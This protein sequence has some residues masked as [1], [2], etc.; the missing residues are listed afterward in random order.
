[1]QHVENL[2]SFR[3][4]IFSESENRWKVGAQNEIFCVK[5]KKMSFGEKI[6][7]LFIGGHRQLE[8]ILCLMNTKIKQEQIKPGDRET[9]I[10]LRALVIKKVE[11]YNSKTCWIFRIFAWAIYGGVDWRKDQLLETIDQRI[12]P[13][14]DRL[15]VST[16]QE[17]NNL[18]VNELLHK[19]ADPLKK[20]E[21][22]N[23]NA[24]EIAVR[25]KN[26]IALTAILK[27]PF[28]NIERIEFQQ[29]FKIM[30]L[31][32]QN[33][34]ILKLLVQAQFNPKIT[35]LFR[36]NLLYTAIWK[37][38]FEEKIYKYLFE[39]GLNPLE[40]NGLGKTASEYAKTTYE[41]DQVDEQGQIKRKQLIEFLQ[42]TERKL[43]S[44]A[45]VNYGV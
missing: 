23:Y 19:G 35:D 41:Q 39:V 2:F 29:Q 37:R 34:E 31:A 27:S 16:V 33:V 17:Q 45:E 10:Q 22:Y 42:E 30:E 44:A 38:I 7:D 43:E 32:L 15:L 1:M 3:K 6:R 21:I 40:K 4:W 5:V 18:K 14:I 36:N 24:L 12:A 13:D 26:E 8:N 20:E 25:C 28:F 9:L 11:D